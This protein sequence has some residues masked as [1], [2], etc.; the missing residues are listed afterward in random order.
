MLS[1]IVLFDG[2][3]ASFCRNKNDRV[4]VF[5][6]R[7]MLCVFFDWFSIFSDFIVGEFFSIS[8]SVLYVVEVDGDIE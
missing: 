1:Q 4:I 3:G 2:I 6:Y 5:T 8:L 7:F